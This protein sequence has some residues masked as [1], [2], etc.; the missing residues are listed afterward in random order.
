MPSERRVTL[1]AAYADNRVIGDHG[2]IPWHIPEDF[3]HFK[4]ETLGHTLV[5]GRLTFDSIGRPL[6]GRRTIVVTRNRSWGADGVEV[7]HGLGEALALAADDEVY[8]A[9]G[10]QIYDLALPLAT[11][12]ILTEV[13]L[14]PPGDAHYPELEAGEWQETRRVTR[15]DLDWV[16]LVRVRGPQAPADSLEA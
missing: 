9:G 2:R 14:S 6:P 7:A 1:I 12:Q 15:P 4:A 11:H 10:T 8:V 16:W 3:A 13:H 5:M